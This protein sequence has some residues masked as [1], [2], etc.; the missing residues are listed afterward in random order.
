MTEK[1][2][3][4]KIFTETRGKYNIL[5][6]DVRLFTFEF[7]IDATLEE[8]RIAIEELLK[9]IE[10]VKE[11]QKQKAQEYMAMPKTEAAVE[12]IVE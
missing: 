11:E 12:P 6:D 1:E 2:P 10:K 3:I 9:A 5:K 7:P 4:F 8:N